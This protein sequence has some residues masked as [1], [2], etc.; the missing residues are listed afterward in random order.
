[1]E[2]L[3]G[4]LYKVHRHRGEQLWDYVSC[5]NHEK[6]S[7]PY[8]NHKTTVNAFQKGLFLDGELYKKLTKFNCTT[9]ENVLGSR[10]DGRRTNSIAIDKLHMTTGTMT[11][12]SGGLA[13]ELHATFLR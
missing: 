9:I 11:D 8:C 7:I 12:T 5:F 1:M 13:I 3:S 2:R 4:D 10:S 6:V